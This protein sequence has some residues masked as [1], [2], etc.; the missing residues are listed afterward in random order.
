MTVNILSSSLI[1]RKT[2]GS[3][4][5][6]T[7]DLAFASYCSSDIVFINVAKQIINSIFVTIFIDS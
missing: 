5:I 6:W 3:G 7:H 2:Y 4:G 1:G